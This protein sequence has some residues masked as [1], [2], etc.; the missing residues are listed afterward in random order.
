MPEGDYPFRLKAME[1]TDDFRNQPGMFHRLSETIKN[2]GG[3]YRRFNAVYRSEPASEKEKEFDSLLSG[4]P[5]NH[6]YRMRGGKLIPGYRL[7]CRE[8]LVGALFPKSME[9]FLDIGCC[10]GYYVFKASEKPS[11]RLALGIDVFE[12]FLSISRQVKGYLGGE[13]ID[14]K[15]AALDE[16]GGSPQSYGGPFQTVMTIGTYHYLFWGSSRSDKAFFDHRRILTLLAGLCAERLIFSGR[17]DLERLPE[18]IAAKARSHKNAD[19]YNT[20]EFLKVAP[21]F[22]KIREIGY[23]GAYPLY[24]MIKK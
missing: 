5:R 22:F 3:Y 2:L 4:Y 11:C 15:M 7:Y 8:R 6:N 16:V 17:L 24:L 19:A 14:F 13:N 18:E 9:S 21:E 12:P 20:A 1:K 10:R 23:L